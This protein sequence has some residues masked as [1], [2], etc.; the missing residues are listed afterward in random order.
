MLR[1][2]GIYCVDSLLSERTGYD[3]GA[4]A[5]TRETVGRRGEAV[6]KLPVR[7]DGFN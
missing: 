5:P 6:H 7:D 3:G 4:R 2:A 1:L